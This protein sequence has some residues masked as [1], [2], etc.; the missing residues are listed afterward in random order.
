MSFC[1][2]PPNWVRFPFGFPLNQELS[3]KSYLNKGIFHLLKNMFIFPPVGLKGHLSLLD[4]FHCFSQGANTR[5]EV[6]RAVP[7]PSAT[8]LGPPVVPFS[9]FS[10]EGAPTKIQLRLCLRARR[11]RAT[12]NT[13]TPQHPRPP[14]P[15]DGLLIPR[16][17]AQKTL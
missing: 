15:C 14:W 10:G 13:W 16:C 9:P 11:A 4:I 5:M 17:P 2:G 8:R 12:L 1:R 3:S 6:R 7:N